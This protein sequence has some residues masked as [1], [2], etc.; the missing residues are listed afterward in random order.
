MLI[1]SFINLVLR[2]IDFVAMVIEQKQHAL[3]QSDNQLIFFFKDF[4]KVI[5]ALAEYFLF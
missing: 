2:F 4:L 1:I 3:S 5:I